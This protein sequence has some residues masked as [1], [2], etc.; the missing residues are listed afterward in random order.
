[1]HEIGLV[2]DVLRAINARLK[3]L[4]KSSKVKRVNILIGKLEHIVP[5]HFEFHFR[6]RTKDTPLKDAE[7]NFKQLEA[8][9]R[10][11]D[12]QREF[13]AEEGLGG[14]PNCK[15]KL[16]DII[17]GTGVFVESVEIV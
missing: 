1:M 11:K 5:D 3:E 17:S 15:S 14:C 16:N 12:C 4:K 2:D 10:C 13:S 8:R 9:F 7:L 6:E